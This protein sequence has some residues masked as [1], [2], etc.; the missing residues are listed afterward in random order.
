MGESEVFNPN[1][2]RMFEDGKSWV[3]K[4]VPEF[5][6]TPPEIKFQYNEFVDRVV[7]ANPK[8]SP[9]SASEKIFEAEKRNDHHF[10]GVN[11]SQ[12][13]NMQLVFERRRLTALEEINLITDEDKKALQRLRADFN[14]VI[15]EIVIQTGDE[16]ADIEKAV[17]TLLINN[18]AQDLLEAKTILIEGPIIQGFEETYDPR[19]PNSRVK[20][21]LIDAFGAKTLRKAKIGRVIKD[22]KYYIFSAYTSSDIEKGNALSKM[23]I[24]RWS[25]EG[26]LVAED[27]EHYLKAAIYLEKMDDQQG[28]KH[29]YKIR[30]TA[31]DTNGF[32]QIKLGSFG[33]EQS[34]DF[35]Y[36]SDVQLTNEEDKMRAYILGTV[37][38]EVAHRYEMQID[39]KTFDDYSHIIDEEVIPGRKKYVSDYVL[40][41]QEIYG[42]KEKDLL[43][44]DFAEAIRIY[45]TNPTYL[46]RN[47]PRRY[48]FVKSNLS[49]IKEG[50][51]VEAVKNISEQK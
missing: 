8:L 22:D 40:R 45:A 26:H 23:G 16:P 44:E 31:G 28:L 48:A 3:R 14:G 15:N 38:H 21:F 25:L 7:A 10:F 49:F 13:P 43:S 47:F 12:D 51:V 29:T 41:H 42:S 19:I 20:Q 5:D 11:Y 4:E 17:D 37:A 9:Q 35:D 27:K 39:K 33:V 18:V 50:S 36:L 24:A 46:Q 6:I 1:Q 34:K 2:H 30:A 32:H